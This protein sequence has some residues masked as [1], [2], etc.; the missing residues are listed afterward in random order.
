MD[1]DGLPLSSPLP[2]SHVLLGSNRN[3]QNQLELNKLPAF[4]YNSR[5]PEPNTK[6]AVRINL[7]LIA[8]L[9]ITTAAGAALK[10]G[11]GVEGAG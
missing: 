1:D 4:G 3:S 9:L 5:S 7:A 8:I 10:Y 2:L 11:D 6:M